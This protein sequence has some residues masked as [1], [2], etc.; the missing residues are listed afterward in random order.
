VYRAQ[1]LNGVTEAD[2]S[3]TLLL[4]PGTDKGR[5]PAV[6][7]RLLRL[8]KSLTPAASTTTTMA[9]S[10]TVSEGSRP[11]LLAG[12]GSGHSNPLLLQERRPEIDR[13]SCGASC[14]R[15]ILRRR[16]GVNGAVPALLSHSTGVLH[17]DCGGQQD[18]KRWYIVES[19]WVKAW[20]AFAHYNKNSPAPGAIENEVCLDGGGSTV[21][22][23]INNDS[24]LV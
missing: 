1:L 23:T 7:R 12:G 16:L 13:R 11:L 17:I 20:L 3:L 8:P 9:S 21:L 10:A 15:T 14:R 4:P 5:C 19:T 2:G 24:Q 18:G 22:Y 6:G